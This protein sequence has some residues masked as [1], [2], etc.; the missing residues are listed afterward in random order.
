M[1][2]IKLSY[3]YTKKSVEPSLLL[4][5]ALKAFALPDMSETSNA[6]A[7]ADMY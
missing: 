1:L 5:H 2:I 7:H 4:F 3:R 6:K